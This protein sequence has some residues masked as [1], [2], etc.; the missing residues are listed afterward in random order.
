MFIESSELKPIAAT[1]PD[2]SPTEECKVS[3][4]VLEKVYKKQL[5]GLSDV[6]EVTDVRATVKVSFKV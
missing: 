4:D 2:F 3:L 1:C 6:T 5:E